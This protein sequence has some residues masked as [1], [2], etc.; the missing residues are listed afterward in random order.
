MRRPDSVVLG[1]PLPGP[2]S[3][4]ALRTTKQVAFQVCR[5]GQAHRGSCPWLPATTCLAAPQVRP[6]H[7]PLPSI[8]PA[9]AQGRVGGK[10]RHVPGDPNRVRNSPLRRP[11]LNGPDAARD[12]QNESLRRRISPKTSASLAPLMPSPDLIS[13]MPARRNGLVASSSDRRDGTV[14]SPL[15]R[16]SAI[17]AMR[18]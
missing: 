14:G 1:G 7:R 3:A 11:F 4:T 12:I 8:P 16:A 10:P 13:A 9:Q 5:R 17:R 18:S 15:E 2:S 6:A